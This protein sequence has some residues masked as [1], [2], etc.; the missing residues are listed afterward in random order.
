MA[1]ALISS[2]FRG[3]ALNARPATVAA[4]PSVATVMPVRAAQ[5]LQG[6]VVSTSGLKTA[7]VAVDV[8]SIH[9]IYLKRVRQTKKYVAHDEDQKC[10][11]GDVVILSPSKPISKRKRFV[12]G[13]I[14]KKAV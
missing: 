9:P 1:S 14:V 3:T 11:V 2:T 10:T 13:E 8:L 5:S 7:V 12:V 4:R 6:K